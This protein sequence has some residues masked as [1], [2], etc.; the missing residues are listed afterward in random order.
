MISACVP[1]KASGGTFSSTNAQFVE[2]IAPAGEA[3]YTI[4]VEASTPGYVS[5]SHCKHSGKHSGCARVFVAGSSLGSRTR[6]YSHS[7]YPAKIERLASRM[8]E[9]CASGSHIRESTCFRRLALD[10]AVMV[11][12]TST[13]AALSPVISARDGKSTL[14]LRSICRPRLPSPLGFLRCR[15]RVG[16][17]HG[18]E[19]SVRGSLQAP[20][21]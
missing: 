9:K 15:R 21:Y 10:G 19:L 13:I 2:W 7:W 6:V 14:N 12:S 20:D 11:A 3:T 1:L 8:A 16:R 4:T 5:G 18:A 17:R